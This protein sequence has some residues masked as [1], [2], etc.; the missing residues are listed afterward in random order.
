MVGCCEYG[1]EPSDAIKGEELH[2]QM[3]VHYLLLRA[4]T[5]TVYRCLSVGLP[6]S[7]RTI[8]LIRI[9]NIRLPFRPVSPCL[10]ALLDVRLHVCAA[11]LAS[12]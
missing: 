2:D 5:V 9:C 1:N 12:F 8:F 7:V 4:V 10:S 6:L 11:C 3:M